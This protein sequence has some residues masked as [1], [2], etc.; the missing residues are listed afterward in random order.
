MSLLYRLFKENA[1]PAFLD[2][3]DDMLN[4]LRKRNRRFYRKRRTRS[5][6]GK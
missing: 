5:M 4:E 1:L 3:M 2:A 6:R